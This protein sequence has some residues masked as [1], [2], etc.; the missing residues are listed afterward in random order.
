MPVVR[1]I[2][3]GSSYPGAYVSATERRSFTSSEIPENTRDMIANALNV[4][5]ITVHSSPSI[6]GIYCRANSN[7]IVLSNQMPEKAVA[8]LKGELKD[9][10]VGMLESNLNAIGNNILTNDRIAIVN[11]DYSQKSVKWISDILGVEIIQAKIGGFKTVGSSNILTN[12]GFAIN[13]RATDEEKEHID[14]VLGFH[15]ER[16]TANTGALSIGLSVV[17]NSYGI[18]VGPETTGFELARIMQA[19]DI[20]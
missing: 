1:C 20:S 11:P 8:A 13:N 15:S 17:C 4:E 9:I 5:P 14:G 12:R 2:I 16:T 3:R 7:G 18:A 6:I 10:N 19:L